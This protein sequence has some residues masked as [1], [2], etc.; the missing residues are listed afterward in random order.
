VTTYL[1]DGTVYR[2]RVAAIYSRALGFADVVV[3][4]GAA[5][6]SHLGPANLAEVLVRGAPGITAGALS[7][8][9]ASLGARFPGLAAASRSAVNAQAALYESQQSYGNNLFLGL[10]TLL[11]AVALVNTLVMATVERRRALRL[12]RRVGATT[13]QLIS[14]TV[15]QTAVLSLVGI[16]IG[17]AAGAAPLIMV[18]KALAGTWSPYVTWPPIAVIGGSAVGLTLISILAPTGCLLTSRER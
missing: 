4:S 8:E 18:S 14:M 1:A 10:V 11:A 6:G 3:P 12:L 17:V 9:V 5:G 2:A 15:W 16:V 7:A 13:R